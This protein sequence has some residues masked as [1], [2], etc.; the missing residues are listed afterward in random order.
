VRHK[1]FT[2]IIM[3]LVIFCIVCCAVWL[4]LGRLI[5]AKE[6]RNVLIISIDT[7][8][9]DFLSCYGFPL[10]T[11]P[12]ID[13][14]AQEGLFCEQVVSPLPITLP[15]HCSMLIGTIPPCHGVLDNA[16]FTLDKDNI[17]LAEM[18]KEQGF[19]TGAL[20]SSYIL[21]SDFGMD[22]GFDTYNDNCE[23]GR[24]TMGI[25]ERQ[26]G[27]TTE[28]VLSWMEKNQDEKQFLFVHYFDPH[29][30]YDAPE[31]FGSKFVSA[32]I[33]R[34]FKQEKLTAFSS[35]AGEVA[36]VDHCIGKI[37]DKL[38]ELGQ[39]DSTLICITS[40]HGEM[41]GQH[42]EQTHGY[43]IY[44]GN[45][46]VP[47]IFK[48]PG[49]KPLEVKSS[50]GLIDIVP[51]ICS[52][53]GVEIDHEIQ[54][55]DLM[56]FYNNDNPY[57]D[58]HLF[59]MSLEATKYHA[60]P[61][62]GVVN[63]RYKYIETTRP[64]LYD[65]P[66]DSYETENLVEAQP[67][68]A[69]QMQGQLQQIIE[70]AKSCKKTGSVRGLDIETLSK[71]ESL[72][73]VGRMVDD[74]FLIDPAKPDP[75][76]FINYHLLEATIGYLIQIGE[77]ESAEKNC[78]EMIDRKPDLY[79]GYYKMAKYLMQRQKYSE[80]IDYIVKVTELEP[81][82]VEGY[83]GL[84]K[85][86]QNLNQFD[87]A[88]KYALKV[89]EIER[90]SISAYYHLSICYYEKGM[91]DEPQKY[92]NREI[93][94]NPR[95]YKVV[96]GLATKLYEKGQI[97]RAHK[98][99]SKLLELDP[100]SYDGLNSMSWL[101]AAS[102][103]DG[104]RNPR[105]AIDFALKACEISGYRKP[106]AIDTLAVA[107]AA[108]GDFQKAIETAQKAIEVVNSRGDDGF[109]GRIQKRLDLY[110]QG[111][112]YLDPQLIPSKDHANEE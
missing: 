96:Q 23:D 69:R 30:T 6:I 37:I 10:E 49:K 22:Q 53:V 13:A 4:S 80:A 68:R 76:D 82:F 58:R 83:I 88:I 110:R 62:L 51:T 35:Y 25:N 77:Y 101:Q 54:G 9:A 8:R 94:E 38:K 84:A 32:N 70:D 44:Q 106:E 19:V 52:A 61:L 2:K 81:D 28:L 31:P 55:K 11:T 78:R 65:V 14:V 40:D 3:L 103:I 46:F 57:P 36:Y 20:V 41:L 86:Y 75:K 47:L 99:Y 26:G 15:A 27:R 104:I 97:R 18:L 85:A 95:Y 74:N 39:Y 12:N 34:S 59:C 16:L 33:F 48:M 63:D 56:A 89:L 90:E 111:K 107:Y 112:T 67:D 73:Y 7:C 50:V 87:T 71:L 64:E 108:A 102:M 21:D 93:R 1:A 43:F 109:A 98:K 79:M 105:Q 24:N 60:N 72:G 17:T 5:W 100:D 42:G 45:I 66:Y 92:L 91:F 29:F